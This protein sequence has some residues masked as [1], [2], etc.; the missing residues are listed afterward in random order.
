[1]FTQTSLLYNIEFNILLCELRAI[2]AKTA[3][4]IPSGVQSTNI[5][6]F[7]R[8][9]NAK[10]GLDLKTYHELHAWSTHPSTLAQ[11][12]SDALEF[13]KIASPSQSRFASSFKVGR[14]KSR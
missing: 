11:F 10:N 3:L 12:W 14:L 1:L 7:R 8:Y 2:M 13:L 6:Y 9:I 4:W 5:E